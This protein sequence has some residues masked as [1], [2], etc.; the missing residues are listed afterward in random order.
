MTAGPMT[1]STRFSKPVRRCVRL[2]A[3]GA[4]VLGV[5]GAVPARAQEAPVE[6]PVVPPAEVSPVD[7]V[8]ALAGEIETLRQSAAAI[9]LRAEVLG[10][11]I[12]EQAVALAA[13][14][15]QAAQAA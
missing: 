4:V 12:A 15:Q 1:R 9:A 3:A 13:H 14:Q 6:A 2:L 5:F 10:A 8:V 11:Q 7:P